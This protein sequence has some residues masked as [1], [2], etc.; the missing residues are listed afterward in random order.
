MDYEGS[1]CVEKK[2]A[3][4]Y[5]KKEFGEMFRGIIHVIYSLIS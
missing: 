3:I 4:L 1:F 2:H 5:N